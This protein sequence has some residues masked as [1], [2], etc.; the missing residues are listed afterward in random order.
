MQTMKLLHVVGV[1]PNFPKLAPVHR[2]GVAHGATQVIVHTGQHYDERLSSSFFNSLEIPEPQ[3]NLAVGSGSQAMQKARILERI[4]PVLERHRPDWML[5]YGDVNASVA[6]PLAA[7]KLGLQTTH[8]EAGLHGDHRRMPQDI[9]RLAT[10]R[11]VDLLLTRSRGADERLRFNG[12]PQSAIAFVGNV[13][14]TTLFHTLARLGIRTAG[15]EPLPDD[16]SAVVTLHWPSNGDDLP[17][18]TEIMQAL[19]RV[20]QWRPIHPRTRARLEDAKLVTTGVRLMDLLWYD[21]LLR[22]V[23]RVNVVITDS[24]GRQEEFAALGIP[25]LTLRPNTERPITITEGTN[26]TVAH[27]RDLDAAIL[28]LRR[29]VRPPRPVGWDGHAGTPIIAVL[30]ERLHAAKSSRE[31][32]RA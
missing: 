6:A 26:R 27:P 20:V 18:F 9:I 4:E 19:A 15:D 2:A 24:G 17:R 5:L 32:P 13:M 23:T 3:E 28:T 16:G 11:L 7:S 31:A 12:E 22:L 10:D 30:A 14:V 8:V 21:N 25:C 29:S 1:R